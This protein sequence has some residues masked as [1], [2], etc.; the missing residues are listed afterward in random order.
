[1]GE[2]VEQ[3]AR[4]GEPT[5]RELSW[6]LVERRRVQAPPPGG[7][8]R[9]APRPA[10]APA[11]VPSLT[12]APLWP[13][14]LAAVAGAIARSR[15]EYSWDNWKLI[16]ATAIVSVYAI[17]TCLRPVPYRDD[18]RVRLRI[19][20]EQAI[21]L[22]VVLATGA[23]AS[24]FALCLIPSGMLAG[25]AAGGFFS[26][27]LAIAAIAAVTAKDVDAI[28]FVDGMRDGL[29]WT[30]LLGLVAFTSGLTHRAGLEAARQ[31]QL[32]LDR[33]SRL[34]E[35]NSLLFS[36]QRVAQ[37]LP[38]S[39]DLDD[40]LD[41]TVQ[42]LQAMVRHDAVSV[43]LVNATDRAVEPIRAIGFTPPPSFQLDRLPEGLRAAMDSPR[44]VRIDDLSFRGGVSASARSGLYAALRARGAL[45]G[46]IAVEADQTDSFG[47][48]QA[49]IVHGL[50]EP[51]GIAIDNARMFGRIRTLAADEERSRIA[52]D[53][54]DHI[55]S[56]LA[57]IGYEIDRAQSIA[58]DGGEIVPV[59]EDLRKQVT[60]VVSDVR[61]TL[62]DLR[63]EVTDT[64]DLAAIVRDFL[65]RVQQ[66]TGIITD[67]DVQIAG[68]LP[69]IQEREMWQIAREAITNV[70][71]HSQAKHLTVTVNETSTS[72]SIS[73]RDDG[74]GLGLHT[75]RADSYGI[76]GMRERAARI[77]AELSIRPSVRGGTEIQV[78]LR[79]D[80]RRQRWDSR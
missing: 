2:E 38:A 65:T 6:P 62:F 58:S 18:S 33:V 77:G 30:G 14:R 26:A 71:R 52:R 16:S 7:I 47:Q 12:A 29:L 72:A 60:A 27:Q 25:F 49:E 36:L 50:T 57:M 73:V 46:L 19:V 13:F 54:H 41:S 68:R 37:T 76:I 42:R 31:Q 74:V 34:A 40:V 66:R 3:R 1:M 21:H 55:G 28:G 48:Q 79:T 67:H 11:P 75:S 39:L 45:V 17:V 56:S 10:T 63:T 32:A 59:L 23:W 80:D 51:F 78:H 8:E 22:I 61:D 24:P 9:R 4:G 70:E 20:G 43:F 15:T 69:L 44:T 53:L 64:Y 5:Q 35:A